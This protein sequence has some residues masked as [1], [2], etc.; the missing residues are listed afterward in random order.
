M[1]FA[2]LGRCSL[3]T[4]TLQ[5]HIWAA[6]DTKGLLS[7]GVFSGDGTLRHDRWREFI[8][9]TPILLW[10]SWQ[11]ST[12]TSAITKWFADQEATDRLPVG[13]AKKKETYLR[14][15]GIGGRIV[16]DV[17]LRFGVLLGALWILNLVS[18]YPK[19]WNE[20]C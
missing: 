10:T 15:G 11:V 18:R 17:G 5:F 2:W 6:A 19:S 8:L 9:L 3:E 4:Y 20:Q 1:G 16:G 12:A 13:V 7:L 14:Q